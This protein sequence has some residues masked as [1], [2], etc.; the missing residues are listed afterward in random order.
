VLE[1]LNHERMFEV[2]RNALNDQTLH[3]KI[4]SKLNIFDT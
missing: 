1:K 3:K 4:V 2:F